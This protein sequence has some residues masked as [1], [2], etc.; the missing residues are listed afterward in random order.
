MHLDFH[1]WCRASDQN[2]LLPI[3]DPTLHQ[4]ERCSGSEAPPEA[5]R[6]GTDSPAL[7]IDE[8][9]LIVRTTCCKLEQHVVCVLQ[10]ELEVVVEREGVLMC[11]ATFVLLD[12]I[13]VEADDPQ[14]TP[15]F[16]KVTRKTLN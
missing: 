15:N 6:D 9:L 3:P 10:P 14:L 8:F 5:G 11:V 13:A 12:T 1:R 7:T 16:E 2:R 4:G